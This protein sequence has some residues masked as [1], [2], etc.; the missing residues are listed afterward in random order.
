MSCNGIT[1]EDLEADQ[2]P[3]KKKKIWPFGKKNK[4]SKDNQSEVEEVQ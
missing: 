2:A 4:K 1:D 3:K